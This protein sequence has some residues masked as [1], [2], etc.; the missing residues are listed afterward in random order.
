MKTGKTVNDGRRRKKKRE[1]QKGKLLVCLMGIAL[2]LGC[3]LWQMEGQIVSVG[4]AETGENNRKKN[5][6]W[7]D[8]GQQDIPEELWELLEKNP[9]TSDFVKGYPDREEYLDREISL[10]EDS[11]ICDALAK[12]TV[13]LLMQWDM[14]WGYGAYGKEMIGLAGCGPV[15]LCMAYIYLTDDLSMDP[16][17]VAELAYKEGFYTEEYG[18]DWGLWTQGAALLGLCGEQLDLGESEIKDVLDGGGVVVCSMRPGDFTT[19][20]H[21]ILLR[22][23]DE[24]GFYVND[25][26]RRSNS[27]RQ[28]SYEELSGQIKNLWG[29]ESGSL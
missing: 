19:T 25:P 26:N 10:A 3:I 14:R 28:W 1:R 11:E 24:N 5:S 7:V 16:S 12:G 23:Y 29:I 9:E 6:A 8:N 15:C 18:T 27:E 4:F 2:V 20:G 17:D 13:P 21:F 22:A